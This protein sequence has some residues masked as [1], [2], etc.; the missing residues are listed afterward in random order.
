MVGDAGDNWPAVQRIYM[1]T[2]IVWTRSTSGRSPPAASQSN[3][4][5]AKET[6]Q[7]VGVV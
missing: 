1:C 6:I 5:S 4:P 3:P 7:I 2:W